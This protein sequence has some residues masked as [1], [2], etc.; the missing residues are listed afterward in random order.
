MRTSA[1]PGNSKV[2]G[3]VTSARD[4]RDH[5]PHS[6]GVCQVR[7]RVLAILRRNPQHDSAPKH[8]RRCLG[9]FQ[10]LFGL[11]PLHP[12]S[13]RGVFEAPGWAS[14]AYSG[15]KRSRAVSYEN[16]SS[17][18][19]RC[20]HKTSLGAWICIACFMASENPSTSSSSTRWTPTERA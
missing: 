9:D 13:Y 17:Y 6:P 12:V 8:D 20:F 10:R 3:S 5:H 2:K 14:V 7:V 15:S 11:E 16:S 19:L 1:I 18:D 4:A